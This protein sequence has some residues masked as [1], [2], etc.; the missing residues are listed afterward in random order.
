MDPGLT[1]N[2]FVFLIEWNIF[3]KQELKLSENKYML[4]EI[5]KT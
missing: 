4:I 3:K 5:I 2:L 1:N